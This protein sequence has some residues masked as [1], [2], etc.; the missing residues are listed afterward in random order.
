LR[1]HGNPLIR[2]K[3]EWMSLRKRLKE[4]RENY[5]DVDVFIRRNTLYIDGIPEEEFAEESL[6]SLYFLPRDVFVITYAL[7][8]PPELIRKKGMADVVIPVE[9]E[10]RERG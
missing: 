5:P 10:R 1:Y 3:E 7:G 4:T 2:G 6:S 8:D 9:E